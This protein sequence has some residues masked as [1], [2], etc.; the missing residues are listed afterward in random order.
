[1]GLPGSGHK[2]FKRPPETSAGT[3]RDYSTTFGLTCKDCRHRPLAILLSQC[4]RK[5][6]KNSRAM[7]SVLS[8]NYC[9]GAIW[10]GV[11]CLCATPGK[12]SCAQSDP[13]VEHQTRSPGRIRP[14]HASGQIKDE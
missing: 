7:R 6:K 5:G 9:G 11:R 1:M 14:D 8:G 12:K 4:A 3:A 10:R 2:E 13:Q